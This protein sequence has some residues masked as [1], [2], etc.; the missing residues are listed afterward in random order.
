M[1]SLKINPDGTPHIHEYVRSRK[2]SGKIDPLRYRCNHPDCT[3]PAYKVDLKDKRTMCSRCHV[4]ETFMD[5]ANLQRSN[6]VCF[7]CANDKKSKALRAKHSV[8]QELIDL[9]LKEEG[10]NAKTN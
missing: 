4:T 3:H 8:L 2:P 5:T 9:G 10:N 1:P 7:K 6:P